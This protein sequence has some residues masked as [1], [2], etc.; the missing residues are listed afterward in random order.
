MKRIP[1]VLDC[2]FESGSMPYAQIHYPF[3]NKDWFE[4]HFPAEFIAE[5][6][7]QTRGW[8]YTLMVLSTALFN[9]PAFKNVVVNG[10]VLTEGGQKMAKRL[11]N[12]PEPDLVIANYGADALRYYMLTSPVCEAES[13]N[14][15]EAGVKEALQKVV[16]LL[17]NVLSFYQMYQKQDISPV[18]K[19]ESTEAKQKI[20]ETLKKVMDKAR[21][22]Y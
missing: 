7:D 10:I 12:Y 13:L 9:K 15:S 3:E 8:F 19:V 20:I 4:K 6:V 21:K 5:G 17:G 16:M 22:L 1:D 2:W 11:K 14:F 18:L